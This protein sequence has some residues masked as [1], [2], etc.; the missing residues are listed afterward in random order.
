MST[1]FPDA[2]RAWMRAALDE[3]ALAGA[4]GDVPI[5]AVVVDNQGRVIA[6]AHNEKELRGD[7]TAH[8]E[9]LA[10][11]AASATLGRWYLEDCALVTTLEPCPMCAGAVLSARIPLVVLGA[12]DD[13]AGAAGTRI[14]ALRNR[15]LP[16][17]AQVVGGVDEAEATQLLRDFF[18]A[19]RG[20]E[21]A[22]Q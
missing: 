20:P 16:H 1:P 8:A 5:G 6:R 19:R 22:G 10:I 7:P 13:K 2:Y 9:V 17:R 11:R 3:A 18:A 15:T 12:W 4:H 21:A 14:D